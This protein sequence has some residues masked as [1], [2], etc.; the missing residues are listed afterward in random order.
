MLEYSNEAMNIDAVSRNLLSAFG[1]RFLFEWVVLC[2]LAISLLA[3]DA[4][5]TSVSGTLIVFISTKDGIVIGADRRSY[6]AVR[7]DRDTTV[8]L[9]FAGQ[10]TVVTDTGHPTWV[11]ASTFEVRYNAASI[12]ATFLRDQNLRSS[13]SEYWIPLMNLL[14]TKFGELVLSQVPFG[15]W[16][17]AHDAPDDALFQVQVAHYV[18]DTRQSSLDNMV[19]LYRPDPPNGWMSSSIS[20]ASRGQLED[21][22]P[23]VFGNLK[24]Y[25]ELK[26][27]HDPQFNCWRN[28]KH[29]KRLLSRHLPAKLVSKKDAVAFCRSLIKAAA[30]ITP[31][32]DK[33]DNHIGSSIDVGLL[34]SKGFTWLY[35]D[36]PIPN[37]P[38]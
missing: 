14:R 27:G 16:P 38:N 29:I 32:I 9:V 23:L 26:S 1:M 12:T 31:V 21:S 28:N 6:D 10:F 22:E 5:A 19:F 18:A 24:A 13:I 34:S 17:S 3:T 37:M 33:S 8:K 11:D 4:G 15:R 7:G 30:E 25:T 35:R 36:Q 20:S 2:G